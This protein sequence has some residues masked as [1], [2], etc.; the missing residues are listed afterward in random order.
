MGTIRG[1]APID[2]VPEVPLFEAGNAVLKDLRS[3]ADRGK[4]EV[5]IFLD[6]RPHPMKAGEQ[7]SRAAKR[8]DSLKEIRGIYSSMRLDLHDRVKSLR[9]QAVERT[10]DFN[11]RLKTECKK[12]GIRVVQAPFEADWQLIEAQRA[13]LSDVIVSKDGDPFMIGGDNIV[14]LLDYWTGSCCLYVRIFCYCR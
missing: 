10:E 4:R 9:T 13:K 8:N 5:T 6:G 7:E 1:A 3:L 11:V 14:S 2:M 12:I